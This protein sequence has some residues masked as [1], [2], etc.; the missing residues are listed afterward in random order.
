MVH[1]GIKEFT[2]KVCD[3]AFAHS[4]SLKNHFESYAHVKK[5]K[6]KNSPNV[7][8]TQLTKADYVA[9]DDFKHN[10]RIQ[11]TTTVM[12]AQEHFF[13]EPP[14]FTNSLTHPEPLWNATQTGSCLCSTPRL[15]TNQRQD[16]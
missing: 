7:L 14:R 9:K 4:S 16:S 3:V 2:C 5:L 12:Q 1:D 13:H 15:Q 6:E 8:Q 10:S 11:G